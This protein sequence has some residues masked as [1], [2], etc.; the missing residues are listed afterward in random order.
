MPG[1]W[2][3]PYGAPRRILTVISAAMCI[4]AGG[5]YALPFLSHLQLNIDP[6]PGSA[7]F[8]AKEAF[9]TAFPLQSTGTQSTYVLILTRGGG[10]PVLNV[11]SPSCYVAGG[12]LFIAS[13]C[14][15]AEPLE[16]YSVGLE[17]WL[18]ERIPG[19]FTD[20]TLSS[21][22]RFHARNYSL[23]QEALLNA[24]DE[25]AAK[26]NATLIRV[27]L[28]VNMSQDWAF[29]SALYA[30]SDALVQAQGGS[31]VMSAE[32]SGF[33]A[34]LKAAQDG[35]RQDLATMDTI[36]LPLAL[37]VF[38]CMLR[39]VRLLL[40]PILNIAVVVSAAFA[41]MYPVSLSFNVASTV[42]S[43]MISL[44]IA[45]SID[46]SLFLL[47]RYREE[48][49]HGRHPTRAVELMM[50]A[51]GHTVLVSGT[52]IAL[53]FAA[54]SAFPV[55]MLKTMGIGAGSTAALSVI[56]NLA[57]T[58]T[59]LLTFPRFFSTFTMYGCGCFCRY[60]SSTR[61]PACGCCCEALGRDPA[62]VRASN[63][64]QPLAP[65]AP[66]TAPDWDP[67]VHA[68]SPER[69]GR[70]TSTS[71]AV[72]RP[73]AAAIDS[74]DNRNGHDGA[75]TNRDGS[76]SGIVE[77]AGNSSQKTF[78][79]RRRVP[80]QCWARVA[81]CTQRFAWLTI[82]TVLLAA[83]PFLL[84]LPKIET[85]ADFALLT[86]R[87]A[88][89]TDAYI[90]LLR[91]F[92]SGT[93]APYALL[94]TPRGGPNATVASQPFF[95]DVNALIH[96]LASRNVSVA[97]G[98]PLL[99]YGWLQSVT[100]F[101][102]PTIVP[103]AGHRWLE[104]SY[105]NYTWLEGHT[106]IAGF[107]TEL[108]PELHF[109]WNDQVSRADGNRTLSIGIHLPYDPFSHEGVSFLKE[110]RG[111]LTDAAGANSTCT[112][113]Q[114]LDTA[115]MHLAGGASAML[116]AISSVY[117]AMPMVIATTFIAAFGVVLIAFRSLAV[118]L[119]AVLSLALTIGWVYGI[120]IW[121]YQGGGLAFTGVQ[122]LLPS[123]HGICWI[124]PVLTFPV[125]VGLG[126]DYDVFLLTRVFEI[127]QAGATNSKSITKALVR[128]GNVITAAG[129]IMAIA[130]CGL[131]L[132]ATGVLNQLACTLVACVL[133][134]TL[135]VRTVLLPA[136]MALLG[137]LNWWP[138]RMPVPNEAEELPALGCE[139]TCS[140][141][142]V[143]DDILIIERESPADSLWTS[144][145]D[146]RR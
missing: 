32:I 47:S 8:A 21:Y 30:Q 89:C 72:V 124:V 51:A 80:L 61:S 78:G 29:T 48:I 94:L 44:S 74:H 115:N 53:C 138:R 11:S 88:P 120:L 12:L 56:V 54:L 111:A 104:L 69:P 49:E 130:F 143:D 38:F 140:P 87:D 85:T 123:V 27:Q 7:A 142:D 26:A 90:T 108:G 102:A 121:I 75:Q 96:F 110:M 114:S 76:S 70:A 63:M 2:A 34:F 119:R 41:I 93:V 65:P 84:Q 52:T 112:C 23:L 39:S 18:E 3:V 31:R 141:I 50:S 144:E 146:G 67:V 5:L 126:L 45:T 131:L 66:M 137:N 79:R 24:H 128:S 103:G 91:L 125:L 139:L 77:R 19:W 59:M 16:L 42:P 10:K 15:L 134:D 101:A 95:D 35:V 122:S 36:S 1:A 4:G 107:P 64:R 145:C 113:G 62:S 43:L 13:R 6:P 58:P 68:L 71:A 37:V 55:D 60:G 28:P 129:L 116:D 40:L 105:A 9:E 132:N 20:Q 106:D 117:T 97:R 25:G 135:V 46:Y 92:G 82:G 99:K 127:R 98:T 57:L 133:L 136:I 83:L 33:P 73:A 14:P 109:L 81:G 86:P 100:G 22:Q 17:S 118:P